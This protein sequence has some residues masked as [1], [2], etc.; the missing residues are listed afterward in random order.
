MHRTTRNRNSASALR[1]ARGRVITRLVVTACAG[2][3]AWLTAATGSTM[4]GAARL[5]V[6]VE[7]YA[8]LYRVDGSFETLAD[9]TVAWQVLTD[10]E[11]IGRFVRSVRSSAFDSDSA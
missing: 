4:P 2:V 9:S 8:D 3:A 11:H 7:E 6:R 10:Y 5:A 1:R